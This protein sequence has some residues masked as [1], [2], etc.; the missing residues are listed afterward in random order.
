MAR[1]H[2]GR[3]GRSSQQSAKYGQF[4]ALQEALRKPFPN[5]STLA[6]N[7]WTLWDADINVF[8]SDSGSSL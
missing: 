8:E 4:T 7:G 1:S 5:E 6:Q 3:G 2:T